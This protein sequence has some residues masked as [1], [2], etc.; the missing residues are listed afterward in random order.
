[1]DARAL[2]KNH[3]E[4]DV[5]TFYTRLLFGVEP[6]SEWRQRTKASV[7]AK[8]DGERARRVVALMLAMPE[9]QLG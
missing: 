2:A 9:A 1:M 8:D 6:T 5:I 7:E 3:G 4:D